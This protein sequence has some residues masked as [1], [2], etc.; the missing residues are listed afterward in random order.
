[1]R[2]ASRGAAGLVAFLLLGELV[3]RSGLAR[4]EFLPPSST[5]LARLVD[6]SADRSFLADVVATVLAWAISVAVALAIAIPAG[7]L[8]GSVP[9]VRAA[10]R[11][12]VEFLRPIPSVAL[13]P[14]AVVLIGQ[15]PGTKIA[16]AAYAAVWPILFN[17]IYA[18]TEVDPLLRETATA[19]RVRRRRVLR[20]V[21]LPSI[22]PFV[23]TG[24][25]LAAAVALILV[26]STELLV[27][28]AR[29]IGEFIS[30]AGSGG[31]RMDL[32]LAAT[33]VAGLVGLV[34][35]A[36]LEA[37]ERRWL[38]WGPTATGEPE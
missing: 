21:V 11:A 22:A 20:E 35:N 6:L 32:V 30:Q 27:G 18:V 1:M 24:V 5:V 33:V 26:V 8:L 19:F 10:T 38:R 7:L 28:G 13:I 17:T 4:P 14:L 3:G 29:G 34:A 15:G 37:V 23:V 25:R 31:G 2:T 16:L 12:L 36:T 9:G